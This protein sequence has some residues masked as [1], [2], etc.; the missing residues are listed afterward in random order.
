MVVQGYFLKKRKFCMQNLTKEQKQPPVVILQQ[1]IFYNIYSMIMAKN[2]Q[3][4]QS[5]CL[6]H[7]FSLKDFF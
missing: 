6:V 2:H 3:K 5:M 1:V 7:E 4:I